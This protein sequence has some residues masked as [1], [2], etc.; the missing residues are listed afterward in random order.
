MQFHQR[1]FSGGWSQ[2]KLKYRAL[3]FG[4]F[5]VMGAPP[6]TKNVISMVAKSALVGV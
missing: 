6:A 2:S 1:F 5:A 4:M 3:C